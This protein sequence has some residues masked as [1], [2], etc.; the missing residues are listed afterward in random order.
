[1]SVHDPAQ[2]PNIFR[3]AQEL[4]RCKDPDRVLNAL[5]A[6]LQNEEVKL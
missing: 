2:Y 1:M 5:M 4:A 6:M 3:V